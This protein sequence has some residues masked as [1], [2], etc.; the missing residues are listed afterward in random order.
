MADR[1]IESGTARVEDFRNL[2]PRDYGY[3]IVKGQFALYARV[4]FSEVTDISTSG[5]EHMEKAILRWE[6]EVREGTETAFIIADK[7]FVEL[8]TD[9]FLILVRDKE[10][11]PI[12]EAIRDQ[13]NRIAT[14]RDHRLRRIINDI[15]AERE[16]ELLSSVHH[17]GKAATR[18]VVGRRGK[19]AAYRAAPPQGTPDVAV[20]P[21]IRTAIRRGAKIGRGHRLEIKREDIQENIRYARIGS[22]ICIVLDTSTYEEEIR[23]QSEGLVHSLFLDAYERRDRVA[24][25][26]SK[27]DRAQI[28]SDFTSD[29]EMVRLKFE[30]AQWGGL[31]PFASGVM[32]GTRLFLA[33]LADSLDAVRI[34][35][36][37]TTGKANVP[38][39]QGGNV[40]RELETLPRQL[41]TIG[42]NPI[43]V[44]V[45]I[46]GSPYLR[47][48]SRQ[49]SGHYYHPTTARYHKLTL[50]H[51]FLG[52]V[53]S[54]DKEKT[55]GVAKTFLEKLSKT[56]G[57]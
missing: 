1:G 23:E 42:L 33:R 38:M 11:G 16:R 53:E 3:E 20:L 52:S 28:I 27:G 17:G 12:K 39:T 35:I 4:P 55:I 15:S 9:R 36:L 30:E 2:L 48:F 51:E 43:V 54:G 50:A 18:L 37:I 26:Y 40:R 10:V 5:L 7:D 32:E 41:L 21:T 13:L 14:G 57:A 56:S 34:L 25:I 45:S 8:D 47:E 49:A 44:D 29:L 19:V 31:S 6:Q 22:Y 46:H 24:L